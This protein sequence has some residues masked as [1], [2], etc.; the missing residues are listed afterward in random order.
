MKLTNLTSFV[1]GT[2]FALVLV[3]SFSFMK[4]TDGPMANQ[5]EITPRE[6]STFRANY[7]AMNPGKNA[8][9][10]IS[11]Q[12][13]EVINAM[14]TKRNG[15]LSGIAGF[16]LYFGNTSERPDAGNLVSIPYV[17]N[18][19]LEEVEPTDNLPVAQGFPANFTS[20]CPPFC[21]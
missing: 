9:V 11:L 7:Q 14:V 8:A 3:S 19:N 6:A 15:D 4:Y 18:A 13:W 2:V 16:R 20:D 1:G 5:E 17:I 21:D 12:Q 10:N